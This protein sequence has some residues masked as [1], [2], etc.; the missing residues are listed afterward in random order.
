MN[1]KVIR[2]I[3]GILIVTAIVGTNLNAQERNDVIK[4]YNEGAKSMQTDIPAD[5]IQ[6]QSSTAF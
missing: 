3:A 1:M 2:K 5:K 4:V 6:R